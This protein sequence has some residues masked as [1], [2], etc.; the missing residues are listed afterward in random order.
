MKRRAF[1]GLA[2]LLAG[3][4]VLDAQRRL[5]FTG[6]G[7]DTRAALQTSDL[8]YMGYFSA[9]ASTEFDA[10]QYSESL[11]LR[12]R[13]GVAR[14]LTIGGAAPHVRHILE[15]TIPSDGSLVMS[16]MPA[17]ATHTRSWGDVV[18]TKLYDSIGDVEGIAN[19]SIQGIYWDPVDLFL[20]VTHVSAYEA[21]G[22]E[23]PSDT[24]L[25]QCTLNDGAG[26]GTG[27]GTWRLSP[28][29]VDS[30]DPPFET[31]GN[32]WIHSL[33]RVPDAFANTYCSGRK[34]GVG[35]GHRAWSIAGR[36]PL[37]FGP[38]LFAMDPP[39][40]SNEDDRDYISGDL[41]RMVFHP[42]HLVKAEDPQRAQRPGTNLVNTIGD[43]V[44][45]DYGEESSPNWAQLDG[46]GGVVWVDG[47]YKHG[48]IAFSSLVS[49][50]CQG[51][52]QASPTPTATVFTVD[53]IGDLQV[54]DLVLVSTVNTIG[55][56]RP[57]SYADVTDIDG[58][59]VT[60]ANK[61]EADD[62]TA[63]S[64]IMLAGGTLFAGTKY[65]GGGPM[66]TRYTNGIHIWAPAQLALAATGSIPYD[67]VPVTVQEWEF[68]GRAYPLPGSRAGTAV[69][70]QVT[71][72]AFDPLTK[73]LYV[74]TR[75]GTEDLLTLIHV[76][77]VD[78]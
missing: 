17:Y 52:I 74:H 32:R 38:A 35:G 71:G 60:V 61:N 36:G 47:V 7:A 21:V 16:G 49:G 20:Y 44:A 46:C 69:P 24:C 1:L 64:S 10:Y 18:Q 5:R 11:T 62:G 58:L 12:Y 34:L 53:D 31:Y 37:S 15:F 26:T 76:Y 45:D 73:R 19:V 6:T 68:G 42:Y 4:T 41:T 40:L 56:L 67:Q 72:M 57:F 29:G 22:N 75:K 25:V 59:V 39:S 13:D 8:T 48:V 63:D 51:V 2:G 70:M 3:G 14:L 54:G 30:T 50:N 27:V 9:P 33:W 78:C 77:A 65:V 28:P 66:A 43:L 23:V 55:N